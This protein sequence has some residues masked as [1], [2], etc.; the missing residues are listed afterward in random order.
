[1]HRDGKT[2]YVYPDRARQQLYVGNPDQYQAYRRAYQDAQIVQGQVDSVLLH[3][4]SV[5]WTYG[6][7][8]FGQ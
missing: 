1:V 8:D 5:T 4:D 3:E 7:L 6:G 2:W